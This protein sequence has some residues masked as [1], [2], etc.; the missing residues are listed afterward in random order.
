MSCEIVERDLDA[1]VDH[2]LDP[3]AAS[4]VRAHL[5]ECAACRGRVAGLEALGRLV[6]A[7]PHYMTPDR[8]R[9]SLTAKTS[10]ARSTRRLV[11]WAA[12]AALVLTVGGALSLLRPVATPRDAI[13][14]DV[15]SGHV[16]SLMVD[17]LF[18][19]QSTDQHTVKPWF[20]G[21]LDFAPPVADLSSM[22]FPLIG[23]RLD[24]I[25]EQP[26]AA[27]VYQRLKHTINVFV[28]P[29]RGD[30][31]TAAEAQTIRGYHVIHWTRDGMSFWAVSD[32][33]EAE[34]G[35]FA[36]ALQAP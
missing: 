15:V 34:L 8:L 6:R 12:A 10:A 16:R 29:D 14:E 1:Y 4:G 5:R 36:R 26:A 17:H 18:D 22:G 28:L 32:V 35:D 19:V 2:E 31:P 11:T 20:L 30:T 3:E 27:L 25:R 23:G 21:R 13:A 9:A 33:N 24:Y 7:T